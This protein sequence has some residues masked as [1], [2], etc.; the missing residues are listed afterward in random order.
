MG[1]SDAPATI[2]FFDHISFIITV[3]IFQKQKNRCMSNNNSTV[4]E[5]NTGWNTQFICKY[6]KRVCSA[7]TISVFADCDAV[8]T[9]AQLLHVIRIIKSFCNE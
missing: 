5:T 1:I 7:V 3:S 2:N 8:I 6:S 4:T 9:F